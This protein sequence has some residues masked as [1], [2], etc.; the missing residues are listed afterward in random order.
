MCYRY[1][2]S[3]MCVDV[4]TCVSEFFSEKREI[5]QR[6]TRIYVLFPAAI[7]SKQF[8]TSMEG[9]GWEKP[10]VSKE[11]LT[12]SASP[13]PR[14]RLT[15]ESLEVSNNSGKIID[16]H[17]W[18]ESYFVKVCTVWFKTALYSFIDLYNENL[19]SSGSIL[20][21]PSRIQQTSCCSTNA[22]KSTYPTTQRTAYKS[23]N[24]STGNCICRL[25]L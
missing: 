12:I 3:P 21:D 11:M 20:M 23:S 17:H 9:S 2:Q 10:L 13:L 14:C 4:Q 1:F 6:N 15:R 22:N 7:C 5:H 8:T 16:Y 19:S 18:T 25:M 24:T